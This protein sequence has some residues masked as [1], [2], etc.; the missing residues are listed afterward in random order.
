MDLLANILFEIIEGV[1]VSW[2]AG[3]SAHFLSQFRAELV[4]IYSQQAAIR[5]I[6]DDELLRVEQVMRHDERANCIV[7]G[8]AAGIADHVRIAGTQAEAVLEEN[9]GVHASEHGGMAARADLEISEVET[10]RKDFVGG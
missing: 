4:F 8:D 5:V 1:E 2:F 6:D 10:A 9:A 7:S 3:D